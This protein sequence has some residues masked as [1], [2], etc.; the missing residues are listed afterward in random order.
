VVLDLYSRAVISWAMGTWLTGEL[1]QHALTMAPT[2]WKPTTGL[3]HH[4]D[5]GSQY[6][7][8]R[9]Q[10]LLSPHGITNSMSRTGN[11]WDNACVESFFGTLTRALVYHRHYATREEAKQDI[12]EYVEVFYTRRRRHS[13]L[14][15]DS[16]A[17]F[18]ARTAV[19]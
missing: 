12:F 3:L 2:H 18:K 17:E 10:R 8:R 4:S 6:A 5:R 7:A 15:D 9:Y 1:A 16:S 19:A 14:D 11:C 13:T